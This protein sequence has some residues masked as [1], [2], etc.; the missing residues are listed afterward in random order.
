MKLNN[1]LI[2]LY[3]IFLY[4]HIRY[5]GTIA[6]GVKSYLTNITIYT[7]VG[8]SIVLTMRIILFF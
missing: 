5:D 6:N 7:A 8:Y 4:L 3:Q 2:Q 1:F